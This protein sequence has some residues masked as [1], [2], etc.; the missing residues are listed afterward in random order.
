MDPVVWTAHPARHRHRDLALVVAVF[1][2]TLGATLT[3]FKS[4]FL[5]GLAG[6]ILIVGVASFLFP[7]RYR[8]TDSGVEAR[9][10]VRRK[11]RKWS[12]L[13]RYTI[14]SGAALVTPFSRP[15]WMDRYRGIMLLLDGA[16]RDRVIA[17]LDERVGEVGATD[18]EPEEEAAK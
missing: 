8:L 9:S 13:R 18:D 6:T 16:D 14:G 5:T 1:F 15:S 10:L 11:F 3:A 17:V 2:L 4:L 12:D 7:T